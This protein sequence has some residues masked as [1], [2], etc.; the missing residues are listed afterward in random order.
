MDIAVY[1][2]LLSLISCIYLVLMT[3]AFVRSLV[4]RPF[5]ELESSIVAMH[6]REN[7]R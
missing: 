7:R 5:M 4:S 2:S 6:Y 1:F 3:S